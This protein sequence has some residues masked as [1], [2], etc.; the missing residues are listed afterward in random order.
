VAQRIESLRE[1][2]SRCCERVPGH[3]QGIHQRFSER[4]FLARQNRDWQIPLF[5]CGQCYENLHFKSTPRT[6]DL[7]IKM[8]RPN[9]P[10]I[11]VGPSTNDEIMINAFVSLPAN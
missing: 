9:L 7:S 1:S 8:M 5:S 2:C 3:Q 10:A 6:I 4:P 11:V